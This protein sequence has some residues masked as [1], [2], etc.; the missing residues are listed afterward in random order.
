MNNLLSYFHYLNY[1]IYLSIQESPTRYALVTNVSNFG[2][3]SNGDQS[4][5]IILL[6]NICIQQQEFY[7]EDT[8]S[9][10]DFEPSQEERFKLV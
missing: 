2:D 7:G 1:Q 3:G 5:I 4:A 6:E 10:N 8:Q 9:R